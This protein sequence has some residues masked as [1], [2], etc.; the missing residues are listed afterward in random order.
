MH[1]LFNSFF[2]RNSNSLDA[3]S[4]LVT[5]NPYSTNVPFLYPLKTSGAIEVEHWLKMG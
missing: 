4:K 3:F 1:E 2:T 5:F